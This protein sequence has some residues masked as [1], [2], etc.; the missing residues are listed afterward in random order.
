VCTR[1]LCDFS[2]WTANSAPDVED[3]VSIFD[4][5]F[6][7]Q[8]MFVAGNGLVE[9][10]A[11]CEAAEVEGLSPAIFVE[12]GAQVIVASEVSIR[13]DT[14]AIEERSSYCLVRVAYSALRA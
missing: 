14:V 5:N 8:V 12:V 4:T 10:F 7:G 3:L 2:G 1:E 9:G 13:L 11:V 6:G